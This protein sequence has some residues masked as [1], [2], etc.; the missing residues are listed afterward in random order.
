MANHPKTAH[1]TW[2][3]WNN[4][5]LGRHFN[6]FH[7][8]S[9]YLCQVQWN[10]RITTIRFRWFVWTLNTF[11]VYFIFLWIILWTTEGNNTWINVCFIFFFFTFLLDMCWKCLLPG[12]FISLWSWSQIQW[13]DESTKITLRTCQTIHMYALTRDST[14]TNINVSHMPWVSRWCLYCFI[15]IIFLSQCNDT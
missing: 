5:E 2:K 15:N 7:C 10:H 8:F 12:Q 6:L 3:T 13:W 1:Q 11:S 4:M 14:T 9:V